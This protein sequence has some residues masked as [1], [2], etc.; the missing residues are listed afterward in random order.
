L[1]CR[2]GG[3]N[4]KKPAISAK[5]WQAL[6]LIDCRLEIKLWQAT[7]LSIFQNKTENEIGSIKPVK[8]NQRTFELIIV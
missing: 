1:N 5:D 8:W 2:N 3:G 6:R 4:K 7:Q